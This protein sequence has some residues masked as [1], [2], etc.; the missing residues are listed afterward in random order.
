MVSKKIIWD[1]GFLVLDSAWHGVFE[2]RWCRELGS[3][4]Y[5]LELRKAEQWLWDRPHRRTKRSN[6][7]LFL[8]GWMMRSMRK[9]S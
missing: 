6:L 7:V 3:E 9:R 8:S 2:E 5:N 1:D 4:R